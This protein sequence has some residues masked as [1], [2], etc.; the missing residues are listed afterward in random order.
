MTDTLSDSLK[1][2]IAISVA[3]MP[4]AEA[5]NKHLSELVSYDRQFERIFELLVAVEKEL[6]P[7]ESARR[8]LGDRGS[9][10]IQK[11]DTS[12]KE[13]RRRLTLIER[14]LATTLKAN[15]KLPTVIVT[16]DSGVGINESIPDID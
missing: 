2:S 10:V 4:Q 3:S 6:A 9:F 1:A 16:E 12:E 5:I 11:G 8:A 14:S 15:R 7:V 13:T